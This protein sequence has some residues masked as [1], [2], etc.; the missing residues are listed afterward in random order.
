MDL[1]QFELGIFSIPVTLLEF[2][3]EDQRLREINNKHVNILF[4]SF[5]TF[6]DNPSFPSVL[7]VSL[8][9]DI[10]PDEFNADVILAHS[11]TVIDGNHRLEALQKYKKTTGKDYVTSV[12]CRV[13]RKLSYDAATAVGYRQNLAN[14][15]F[16]KMTDFDL[17]C[18]IRKVKAKTTAQNADM[19]TSYEQVYKHLGINGSTFVSIIIHKLI[20]SLPLNNIFHNPYPRMHRLND[21]IKYKI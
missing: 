10:E 21:N 20:F 15:S 9:E 3:N 17:C 7:S 6:K 18:I 1:S 14:K 11:Y 8:A 12:N 5:L 13:Y 4:K 2:P 19:K 16:Y